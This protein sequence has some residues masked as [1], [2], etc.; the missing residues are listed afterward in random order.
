[1]SELSAET[2][3]PHCGE[4]VDAHKELEEGSSPI[5]GSISICF[6]CLG[7]SF[8]EVDESRPSN[9]TLRAMTQEEYNR[10]DAEMDHYLSKTILKMRTY[11]TAFPPPT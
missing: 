3:C 4:T 11:K 2:V 8:F 1:M 6:Y 7:I 10:I 5:H 9:L